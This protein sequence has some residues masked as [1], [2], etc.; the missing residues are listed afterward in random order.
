MLASKFYS[1]L[2]A[3]E[4]LGFLKG[5]QVLLI[6]HKMPLWHMNFPPNTILRRSKVLT[7]KYEYFIRFSICR[8]LGDAIALHYFKYG[9]AVK[10]NFP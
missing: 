4:H 10:Q 8:H 3:R 1:N 6:S 7:A 9:W 5:H 2:N